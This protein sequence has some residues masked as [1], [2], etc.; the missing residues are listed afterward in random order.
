[1]GFWNGGGVSRPRLLDPAI[2]DELIAERNLWR[3][4]IAALERTIEKM[5]QAGGEQ[6]RYTFLAASP[7][8]LWACGLCG[9]IVK[10]QVV[11]DRTHA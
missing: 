8:D 9:A 11:H 4:H 1:M 3:R 7:G 2:S 6:G 10:W 5:R